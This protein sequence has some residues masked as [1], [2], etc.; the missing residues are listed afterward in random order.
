LQAAGKVHEAIA[1]FGTAAALE[2]GNAPPHSN[3]VYA[4]HFDPS[5]DTRT[6]LKK[7]LEWDERHARPLARAIRRHENDANP[8]RRLRIGYVSPDFNGHVVGRNILPLLRLRDKENFEVFCYSNGTRP[9]AITEQFQ[10]YADGWR[11]IVGVSDERAAENIREDRI[12]ILV[13]L[14]LHM[15]DSRMLLFAR[16]PAPVQVT[17][18]G[19]PGGT[20]L[21][22]MDHRLTD[23]NLD[24]PGKHDGF[25]CEKSVRLPESFWC[26]DFAAMELGESPAVNALPAL[27]AGYVT[28][29]SLNNFVK[30]NEETFGLWAECLAAVGGA[31]GGKAARRSG[32]RGIRGVWGSREISS[33][34][35]ADRSGIGYVSV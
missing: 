34:V 32:A 4:L 10:A 27:T 21:K 29:G 5:C 26:Y 17:F 14:A 13:D 23:P 30:T 7:H 8:D 12:D 31:R 22:A 20:G 3:L 28:F 1:A 24:P 35:S 19:Y 33:A 25:Y 9:D 11:D 6:M 15:R 18:G 16:K 2:P